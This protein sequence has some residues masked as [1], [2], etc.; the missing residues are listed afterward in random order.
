MLLVVLVG[1]NRRT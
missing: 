1:K